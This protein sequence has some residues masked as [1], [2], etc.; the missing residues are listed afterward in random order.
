MPNSKQRDKESGAATTTSNNAAA[1]SAV[2]TCSA[3]WSPP[4]W[5]LT[6]DKHPQRARS[7][8]IPIPPVPPTTKKA[9][10]KYIAKQQPPYYKQQAHIN[11]L[12]AKIFHQQEKAKHARHRLDR[13]EEDK[14]ERLQEMKV[15]QEE[16]IEESL[17]KI[18]SMVTKEHIAVQQQKEEEWKKETEARLQLA[19]KQFRQEQAAEE[20]KEMAL[21]KQKFEEKQKKEEE[22]EL[23]KKLDENDKDL[24][25]S[26]KLEQEHAKVKAK[27]D[28]LKE[29]KKEMVWLLKQVINA[30]NKRKAAESVIPKKKV[31][32]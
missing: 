25:K 9:I 10:Q 4:L 27:L 13:L 31:K 8:M 12:Q 26:K 17:K 11:Q 6:K 14:A 5:L 15:R 24:P 7:L 2:G 29:T 30:E 21:H 18:S 23:A 16:E 1:A 28:N 3:S 22:E 19:K 32:L 20:E